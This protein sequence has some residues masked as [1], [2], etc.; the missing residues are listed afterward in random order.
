MT[1][2]SVAFL[3]RAEGRE[4]ERWEGVSCGGKVVCEGNPVPRRDGMRLKDRMMGPGARRASWEAPGGKGHGHR[5]EEAGST[6]SRQSCCILNAV[7]RRE[8]TGSSPS[9]W[10]LS[11]PTQGEAWSICSHRMLHRTPGSTN[12]PQKPPVGGVDG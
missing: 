12:L 1:W 3:R 11:P 2:P 9:W 7:L 8:N 10:G 5:A 6:P 4:Q